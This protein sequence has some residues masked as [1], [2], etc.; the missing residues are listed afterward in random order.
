MEEEADIGLDVAANERTFL[1]WLSMATTVG[2]IASALA[3]YINGVEKQK[4][5]FCFTA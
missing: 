5:I 4:G 1:G 3:G 2:G